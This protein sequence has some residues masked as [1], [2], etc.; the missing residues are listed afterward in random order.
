MLEVGILDFNFA[1]F[2]GL[3]IA[4]MADL[5]FR[6]FAF[7]SIDSVAID[8]C[9]YSF[10]FSVTETL[11]VPKEDERAWFIK[12]LICVG[13]LLVLI[14]THIVVFR[15][16]LRGRIDAFGNDLRDEFSDQL[17]LPVRGTM[18]LVKRVVPVTIN[19]TR[20]ALRRGKFTILEE[21]ATLIA[22]L[23][24]LDENLKNPGID[25][26]DGEQDSGERSTG[27]AAGEDGP[28]ADVDS[29]GV[30]LAFTPF[31]LERRVRVFLGTLFTLG[32]SVAL[33]TPAIAL[34]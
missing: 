17:K 23:K 11:S 18:A 4:A 12:T 15:I 10:L 6:W 32:A 21:V 14:A 28:L 33:L 13:I 20:R 34:G 7:G 30:P 22:A 1:L 5:Y 8:V 27:A 19:P 31:V 3:F 26:L 16:D 29:D 24:E 2:A 25:A 9:L